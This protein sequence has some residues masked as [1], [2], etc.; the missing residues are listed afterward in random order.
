MKYITNMTYGYNVRFEKKIERTLFNEKCKENGVSGSSVLQELAG[1]YV[2]GKV[3]V[4]GKKISDIQ[5]K[6]RGGIDN[7]IVVV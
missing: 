4:S 7:G 6:N 2:M 3:K 1:L 5:R